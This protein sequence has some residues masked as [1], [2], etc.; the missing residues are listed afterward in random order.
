MSTL[1]HLLHIA[2]TVLSL[3]TEGKL[4]SE[5][6]D[7]RYVTSG[8]DLV[9][10]ST[11]E[12]LARGCRD[13]RFSNLAPGAAMVVH[14][15]TASYQYVVYNLTHDGMPTSNWVYC[16]FAREGTK[17]IGSWCH[18]TEAGPDWKDQ[19]LAVAACDGQEY[20]VVWPNKRVFLHEPAWGCR[21][22][23]KMDHDVYSAMTGLWAGP[24]PAPQYNGESVAVE[25]QEC[26]P[27]AH[28]TRATDNGTWELQTKGCLTTLFA[29]NVVRRVWRAGGRAVRTMDVVDV[30]VNGLPIRWVVKVARPSANDSLQP[31]WI[32]V[33]CLK[34][35]IRWPQHAVSVSIRPGYMEYIWQKDLLVQ[36]VSGGTDLI[37][38]TSGLLR[39][40]R[41]PKYRAHLYIAIG[42]AVAVVLLSSVRSAL[43]L[44]GK[45]ARS[46]CLSS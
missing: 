28:W 27:G 14:D 15:G 9:Q 7:V 19:E 25:E 24:L 38:E 35:A 17:L 22:P 40:I 21:L 36:R 23:K 13:E 31:G 20:M 46:Q 26:L 16:H 10:Q 6:A 8:S 4:G 41:M 37:V 18:G 43:E 42:A 30:D 12:M 1:L 11:S 33:E 34:T 45:S 39:K 29:G 44:C 32:S 2:S 5:A 3:G